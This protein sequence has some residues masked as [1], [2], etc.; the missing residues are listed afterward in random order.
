M[1]I[2][3]VLVD[4]PPQFT[5]PRLATLPGRWPVAVGAEY[6]VLALAQSEGTWYATF[7]HH[8]REMPVSA[9]LALFDIIDGRVPSC[10]N[11]RAR[12]G[13]IALQ[14]LELD[15]EFFCD[16]VQERRGDALDRYRRM[17]DRVDRGYSG[18]SLAQ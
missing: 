6:V 7:E 4:L 9:P 12:D 1:R 13:G 2:R 10:W 16:D 14:P 8:E 5:S 3:C 17:K 18:G 15:D 11:V